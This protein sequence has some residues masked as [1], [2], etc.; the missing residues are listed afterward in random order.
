MPSPT[1]FSLLELNTRITFETP[2][3]LT[4]ELASRLEGIAKQKEALEREEAEIRESVLNDVRGTVARFEFTQAEVFGNPKIQPV[5][6]YQ[7]P[8]D[9]QTWTGK[10][11]KP[12]WF[13]KALDEGYDEAAMRIGA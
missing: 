8:Y 4:P 1:P 5:A 13:K 12:E 10:G 9:S 7:S 11:R 6:R 2:M 3:I